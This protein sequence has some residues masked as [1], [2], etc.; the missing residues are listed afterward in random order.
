MASWSQEAAVQIQGAWSGQV[1]V[2]LKLQ[3]SERERGMGMRGE[4]RLKTQPADSL[5]EKQEVL[6]VG[7]LLGT[8][9]LVS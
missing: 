8:N 3:V 9:F 7:M 4:G 2:W 6:L 5:K 1:W